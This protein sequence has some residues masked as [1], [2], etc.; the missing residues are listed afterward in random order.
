MMN[1]CRASHLT[2]TVSTQVVCGQLTMRN[3]K[4]AVSFDVKM[5][6]KNPN[7]HISQVEVIGVCTSV[8]WGTWKLKNLDGDP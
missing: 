2:N 5:T 4:N 8:M 3:G 7:F 1:G 6:K